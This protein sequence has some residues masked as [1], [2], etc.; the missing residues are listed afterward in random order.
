M[1]FVEYFDYDN[2]RGKLRQIE[3]GIVT[4]YY[5]DYNT[6]ELLVVSPDNCMFA[7]S[8]FFNSF[9]AFLS[10]YSYYRTETPFQHVF[11]LLFS[12]TA[13]LTYILDLFCF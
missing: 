10:F 3:N 2:N 4:D 6:N 9:L 7:R 13:I 11:G 8:L 12:L 5:Y 1:Q